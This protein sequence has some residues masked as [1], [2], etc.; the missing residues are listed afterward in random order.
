MERGGRRK[1]STSLNLSFMA[2]G[3]DKIV[4]I[5]EDRNAEG[6]KEDGGA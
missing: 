6:E 2:I 4:P 3:K 5:S 1:S